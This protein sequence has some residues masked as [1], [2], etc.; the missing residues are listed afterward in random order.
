MKNPKTNLEDVPYIFLALSLLSVTCS[1]HLVDTRKED[2]TSII[3]NP[4]TTYAPS[5]CTNSLTQSNSESVATTS[6]ICIHSLTQ[7]NSE[8]APTDTKKQTK[9][10][11]NNKANHVH[12]AQ[13]P[14]QTPPK[15]HQLS[16]YNTQVGQQVSLRTKQSH[17]YEVR[18]HVHLVC[19]NSRPQAFF[20]MHHQSYIEDAKRSKNRPNRS[21]TRPKH[22]SRYNKPSLRQWTFPLTRST[23]K[24]Q[25]AP[26]PDCTAK[27][28]ATDSN[29]RT[30]ITKTERA[31]DFKMKVSSKHVNYAENFKLED[32]RSHIRMHRRQHLDRED[33][34]RRKNCHCRGVLHQLSATYG[35]PSLSR[36]NGRRHELANYSS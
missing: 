26:K 17:H 28:V 22:T 3:S 9:K 8:S 21:K 25:T 34:R 10:S 5:I 35:G 16:Y 36:T 20:R 32:K 18:D 27:I 30:I 19:E 12:Q 1:D 11:Y 29:D 6:S 31:T 33:T 15:P 7:S 2:Y 4:N 13:R 14:L 23:P 24:F